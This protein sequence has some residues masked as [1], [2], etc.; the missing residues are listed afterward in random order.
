MT[1][2]TAVPLRLPEGER[3][4]FTATLRVKSSALAM[5]II[6]AVFLLKSLCRLFADRNEVICSRMLS[7]IFGVCSGKHI[8]N[9]CNAALTTSVAGGSGRSEASFAAPIYNDIESCSRAPQIGDNSC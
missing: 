7:W 5:F 6:I 3:V 9:S 2:S 8:A 4:S 1:F